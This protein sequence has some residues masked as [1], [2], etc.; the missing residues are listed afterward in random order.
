MENA[1]GNKIIGAPNVRRRPGGLG[2]FWVLPCLAFALGAFILTIPWALH[3]GNAWT[4]LLYWTGTGKLVTKSG[5]FPL[6]VCLYPS[7]DRGSQLRLDGLRPT[8]GVHG[9]GSLCTSAQTIVPL[10]LTGT[11]YAAWRTTDGALMRFRLLE[12]NGARQLFD[13][14]RRGYFD[15]Y[16]YWHGAQLMMNDRGEYSS[17]FRSGLRIE[18]A[19]VTLTR[20]GTSEFD[21]L[22]SSTKDDTARQ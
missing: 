21:A 10:D 19:S 2:M 17:T 5:I 8:S 6:Y 14:S 4:P 7:R 13:P 12:R 15:L 9:W 1:A 20:G 3:I 22:C 18:H 11:I 16:G